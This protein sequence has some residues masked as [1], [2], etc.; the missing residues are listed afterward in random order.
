M[1]EKHIPLQKTA[2]T[3]PRCVQI[4]QMIH[5][6]KLTDILNPNKFKN[7]IPICGVNIHTS[8][9]PQPPKLVLPQLFAPQ[10]IVI[11]AKSMWEL[12]LM[13]HKSLLILLR[14]SLPNIMYYL[15]LHS[16][17]KIVNG[18]LGKCADERDI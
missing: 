7:M 6:T 14:S 8:L 10:L 3:L 2:I 4:L 18:H 15:H 13:F 17:W 16:N 11:H 5:Q 1:L 9:N 12:T